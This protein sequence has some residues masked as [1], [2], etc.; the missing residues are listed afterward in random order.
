MSMGSSENVV[1]VSHDGTYVKLVFDSDH[2]EPVEELLSTRLTANPMLGSLT[3]KGGKTPRGNNM[4][5]LTFCDK[6]SLVYDNITYTISVDKVP[7]TYGGCVCGYCK[8]ACTCPSH[9]CPVFS[10]GFLL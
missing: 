8:C 6:G 4:K 3:K 7:G 9:T 5:T 10:P 1:K 2:D